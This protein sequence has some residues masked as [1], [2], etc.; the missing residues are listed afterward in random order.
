MQTTE[1]FHQRLSPIKMRQAQKRVQLFFNRFKNKCLWRHVKL[2]KAHSRTHTHT[3]IHSHKHT[4]V[5]IHTHAQLLK[6]SK[7]LKVSRPLSFVLLLLA[8]VVPPFISFSLVLRPFSSRSQS[9]KFC[10]KGLSPIGQAGGA[11]TC[12][13]GRGRIETRCL[14]R[15]L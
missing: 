14:A 9:P 10:K 7:Q 2:P 11:N 15:F 6:I 13:T 3:Q 5:H 1:D 12:D 4:Y 8:L